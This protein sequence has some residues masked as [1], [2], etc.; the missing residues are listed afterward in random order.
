M[1]NGY[2]LPITYALFSFLF[3]HQYSFPFGHD[4]LAYA[5]RF[6]ILWAIYIYKTSLI[7][8]YTQQFTVNF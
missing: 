3:M 7:T 4:W 2:V 6:P 5:Y 8:E 1:P